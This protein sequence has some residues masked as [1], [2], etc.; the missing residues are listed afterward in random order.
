MNSLIIITAVQWRRQLSKTGLAKGGPDFFWGGKVNR[1]YSS[2]NLVI[3]LV[4]VYQ[5][6]GGPGP[7]LAPLA[8]PLLLCDDIIENTW[9]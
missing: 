7:H 8:S 3:I 1:N 6:L 5:I 4:L 9:K 2:A